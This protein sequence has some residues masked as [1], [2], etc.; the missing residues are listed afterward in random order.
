MQEPYFP[1][2]FKAIPHV[3]SSHQIELEPST[4]FQLSADLFSFN[5]VT[6]RIQLCDFPFSCLKARVSHNTCSIH[7]VSSLEPRAGLL[8]ILVSKRV[9]GQVAFFDLKY[10]QPSF[11]RCRLAYLHFFY[12][13]LCF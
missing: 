3:I 2:F 12:L 1:S 11:S 7:E 10:C 13:A 4:N 9:Q 6:L 5:I 8:S